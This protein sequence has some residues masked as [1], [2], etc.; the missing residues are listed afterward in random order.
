MLYKPKN[1]YPSSKLGPVAYRKKERDFCYNFSCQA[2]G[3]EQ[4]DEII[5]LQIG[6]PYAREYKDFSGESLEI[7]SGKTH[8]TEALSL[9]QPPADDL[10]FKIFNKNY[11]SNCIDF[12]KNDSLARDAMNFVTYYK[13]TSPGNTNAWSNLAAPDTLIQVMGSSISPIKKEIN[14]QAIYLYSYYTSLVETSVIDYSQDMPNES[15]MILS[16]APGADFDKSILR[17]N[18]NFSINIQEQGEVS[19][20]LY[21]STYVGKDSMDALIEEHRSVEDSATINSK[22]NTN[23][24]WD[25]MKLNQQVSGSGHWENYLIYSYSF[26]L[27]DQNLKVIDGTIS[28]AYDKDKGFVYLYQILLN[29]STVAYNFGAFSKVY[30]KKYQDYNDLNSNAFV[31]KREIAEKSKIAISSYNCRVNLNLSLKKENTN[32]SKSILNYT[33]DITPEDNSSTYATDALGQSQIINL[34]NVNLQNSDIKRKTLDGL[35]NL[36]PNKNELMWRVGYKAKKPYS[37]YIFS[38]WETFYCGEETPSIE[39]IGPTGENKFLGNVIFKGQFEPS[40]NSLLNESLVNFSWKLFYKEKLLKEINNIYSQDFRFTYED[41]IPGSYALYASVEDNYGNHW[42]SVGYLFDVKYKDILAET[43]IDT[44]LIEENTGVYVKFGKPEN[45]GRISSFRIKRKNVLSQELLDLGKYNIAYLD[46]S[47]LTKHLQIIDYS[48]PHNAEVE[49][50][51]YYQQ[52]DKVYEPII[53]NIV[54]TNWDKWCLFTTKEVSSKKLGGGSTD[55]YNENVLLVDKIFFFEMNVE[56]GNMTNNTDFSV[57]KN[58]TPYP[59]VQRSPSNYWSGQLKGLL[60]RLAINN[61]TF[62]QTPDMLQELKEL[63]QNTSRKFLKDRDGNF[64]EVELSSAITIDNNDKLDVQLKTKSFN[65]VEVGDA[66]DIALISIGY[67][68]DDWLLTE[69]GQEKIDLGKYVWDDDVI[70]DDNDFWTEGESI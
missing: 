5:S 8:I 22:L 2:D 65:W 26:S 34:K 51:I 32:F 18:F 29:D 58:F 4:L 42:S 31:D 14:G 57:V 27:L 7:N 12:L 11:Q 9:F 25:D 6:S 70:W 43:Q 30:H 44:R 53:S 40:K 39:I 52:E 28:F 46:D 16:I 36:S 38:S 1:L 41:F 24:L 15:N 10:A 66:S 64:W 48:V 19:A 33:I 62:K 69:L 54:K 47:S 35:L 20:T 21:Y 60:G 50:L 45:V 49:Y 63:T 17:D 23:F 59:Q 68:Q 3:N 55:G 13:I 56:T 67:G 61:A 37:D